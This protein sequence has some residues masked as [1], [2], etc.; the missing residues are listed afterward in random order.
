MQTPSDSLP[1]DRPQSEDCLSLDVYVPANVQRGAKRDVVFWIYGGGNTQG[2]SNLYANLQKFADSEGFVVVAPNYRLGLFGFFATP[3]L[4]CDERVT[5]NQGIDDLVQALRW[6][7]REIAH[8]GG[9]PASVTLWAR[10][11]AAQIFWRSRRRRPRSISFTA[12]F[13]F[14]RRTTLR[15]APTSTNALARRRSRRPAARPRSVCGQ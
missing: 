6:V 5:G 15:C 8:F 7:Q 9:N 13:R 1:S 10:A 2:F 4:A 14:R 3:E 12:P 11:R